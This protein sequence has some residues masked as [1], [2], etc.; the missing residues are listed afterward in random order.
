[1]NARAII[2]I[3]A[4]LACGVIAA[5]AFTC[6]AEHDGVRVV[7]CD[8][9]GV[10]QQGRKVIFCG[11]IRA[12]D[13]DKVDKAFEISS[14]TEFYMSSP[15]GLTSE[16]IEMVRMLNK[17][18]LTV[19]IFDQCLSACAHFILVGSD[20]VSVLPGTVIGFHH[21]GAAQEALLKE[22]GLPVPVGIRA[23]VEN[24]AAEEYRFY[25][26]IGIDPIVLTKPFR[27]LRPEC[28]DED[29]VTSED[30]KL[31]TRGVWVMWTPRREFLDQY[32]KA[33]IAGWWPEDRYQHLRIVTERYPNLKSPLI[34]KFQQS[35]DYAEG[36]SFKGL[37]WCNS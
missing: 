25:K 13:S 23:I 20:D 15:G 3:I 22:S 24:R 6:D 16:A 35:L 10:S 21:T 7:A 9:D 32:R 30:P 4:T 17:K 5:G 1:M 12:G 8:G 26:E 28:V 29:S 34:F 36:P 37:Q 18:K 14:S 2:V 33:P 31:G 19:K 11:P 27:E